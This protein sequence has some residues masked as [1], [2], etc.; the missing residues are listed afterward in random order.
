MPRIACLGWGSLIW[1][2]GKLP[3]QRAWFEDGPFIHVD[4]LRESDSGCLTLVLHESAPAVRSLWAIMD[5]TAVEQAR[6]ELGIRERCEKTWDRNIHV[7]QRGQVTPRLIV[8]LEQ[9]AQTH[10]VEAVIWTGLPP[11]RNGKSGE[12]PTIEQALEYLGKLPDDKRKEAER[13]IRYS[14]PQID[15]PYR[16]KFEAVLQWT[17]LAPKIELDIS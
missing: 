15:T 12:L 16:R 3:I 4:F 7:W 2:P 14:P 8:D 13:Y 5:A 11:R 6:K 9:W 10:S 17:P 1:S